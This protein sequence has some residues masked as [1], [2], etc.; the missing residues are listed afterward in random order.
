MMKRRRDDM[1]LA[2]ADRIALVAF[3]GIVLSAAVWVGMAAADAAFSATGLTFLDEVFSPEPQ[4]TLLRLSV[5]VVVLALTLIVQMIYS[6]R[7]RVE[8]RLR[9]EQARTLEMYEHSPDSV[10]A[11]SPDHKVLYSNPAAETLRPLDAKGAAKGAYCFEA[12]HGTSA[13]CDDCP[14]PDVLASGESR[15]RTVRDDE[16]GPE[17]WLEQTF[18][19]V[20]KQS[21]VVESVVLVV[22]DISE[23]VNSQRMIRHMAFHDS[24]T[25][26]PN[27]S[28]FSDRLRMALARAERT[29]DTLAIAFVDLNDF[30]AVNDTFGHAVGDGVLRAVGERLV[31]VVRAEDTVARHSGDE[32]T[33]LARVSTR[34]DVDRVIE[35]IQNAVRET[36]VVQGHQ[37]RVTA[38]VGVSVFPGD[39]TNEAELIKNADTAMYCAKDAGHNTWRLYAP[40]MSASSVDRLELESAMRAAFLRDQFELFYQPQIDVRN[41]SIVGVEGL[42]RWHH[43]TQGLLGP[44][45]FLPLAE[46]TGLLDQL[47]PWALEAACSQMRRWLDS[48][49]DFGRVSVNLSTREFLQ[50]DIVDR[51]LRALAKTSLEP[52]RLE[53]EI[54]ETAAIVNSDQLMS[55]LEE[56]RQVGVRVA[57]D[58]FGTGYS[59]MSYL[60]QYPINTVKIAQAFM[61]DLEDDPKSEAIA[62][63][64]IELC[65]TLGLEVVAEGVET[66]SQLEFLRGR[67]CNIVQGYLF[68]EAL[69]ANEFV[70]RLGSQLSIPV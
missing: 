25:G 36:I 49:R 41:G 37:I 18:Y 14:I 24:L 34:S 33:V 43:P 58:D 70:Q 30:K 17:R 31:D 50:H 66:R 44:S 54:T 2:P 60:R 28:L 35:R 32:F 51:V 46:R 38:S 42:L 55:T 5:I 52:Q 15:L 48:G 27:R 7:M 3:G 11:I 21:G 45:S 67:G 63:M 1:A 23:R 4:Q 68:S 22:R 69:P 65:Q 10:I 53:L 8:E 61:S 40:E 13:I 19:P 47:G 12:F 26:L 39:G 56:L 6:R 9:L 59:S 20:F 62:A 57:I 16:H 29:K 64:I